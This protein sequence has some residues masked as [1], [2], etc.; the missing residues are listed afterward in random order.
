MIR[1]L[2]VYAVTSKAAIGGVR[3]FIDAML[4]APQ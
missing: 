1:I 3:H 2:F 4:H